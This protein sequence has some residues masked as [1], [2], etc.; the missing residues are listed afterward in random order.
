MYKKIIGVLL[1]AFFISVIAVFSWN[2]FKKMDYMESEYYPYV[3][4]DDI[5]IFSVNRGLLS[6][7]KLLE[8]YQFLWDELRANFPELDLIAIQ[9]KLN[10][11]GL[12]QKGKSAILNTDSVYL[13]LD[14][15]LDILSVTVGELGEFL[16]IHLVNNKEEY[17]NINLL[18]QN[19]DEN[20]FSEN[21]RKN[22]N[23]LLFT[24]NRTKYT[25]ESLA[26]VR[27]NSTKSAFY[28]VS[29]DT[30]VK[31][32]SFWRKRLKI[33]P[34]IQKAKLELNNESEI[35]ILN[36]K[37]LN[38]YYKENLNGFLF[39]KIINARNLV[40]DLREDWEQDEIL[41]LW[42]ILQSL[43]V[44]G[45]KDAWMQLE[46]YPKNR[47]IREICTDIFWYDKAIQNLEIDWGKPVVFDHDHYYYKQSLNYKRSFPSL[48]SELSEIQ[49]LPEY[50][51]RIWL[52]TD[53]EIGADAR[54]FVR[55]CQELNLA[56]V[57]GLPLRGTN[58]EE[59]WHLHVLP[60]SGIIFFIDPHIE[61]LYNELNPYTS[62]M[63]PDIEVPVGMDALE[64]CFEKIRDFQKNN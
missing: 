2:Q 64:I 39:D 17:K 38:P 45:Q 11:N 18:C 19:S 29:V 24:N 55:I 57:V 3:Y 25:Y 34:A 27:N 52:L 62:N 51:G 43:Y 30:L 42:T 15:W 20:I 32:H 5:E 9:N 16:P 60:H 12:Y 35:F 63:K 28:A 59:D 4:S 36:Q 8:E 22:S 6:R 40:V 1:L 53:A 14:G 23:C 26:K 10:L 54:K 48:E 61:Y 47:Y 37:V 49:E 50:N 33:N 41:S 56:Q 46:S 31:G 21:H 7:D 13:S 58:I 44:N